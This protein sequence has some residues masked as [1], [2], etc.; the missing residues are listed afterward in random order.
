VFRTRFLSIIRSLVLHDI[1]LLLCVQYYIPDD[2]QRNCPK[3]V[4]FYSKNKF[5]K[6]VHL[7]G[8]IIRI[9]IRI[10]G[11]F[12]F[13]FS[14][15]PLYPNFLG[16]SEIFNCSKKP[17]PLMDGQLQAMNFQPPLLPSTFESWN[18]QNTVPICTNVPA[19]IFQC[20]SHRL[21]SFLFFLLSLYNSAIF[22]SLPFVQF[23]IN[24]IEIS[25][26]TTIIM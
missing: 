13:I 16:H 26:N 9:R 7:V 19:I 3:H 5:E 17:D 2:G 8:F 15:D 12:F 22:E 23:I 4:E 20:V 24:N 21:V 14:S 11:T 10:K 1:Y 18:I 25:V 6:L